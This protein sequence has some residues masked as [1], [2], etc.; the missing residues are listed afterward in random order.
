MTTHES[1]RHLDVSGVIGEDDSE[2]LRDA[3]HEVTLAGTR[4]ATVDLSGVTRLSGPAVRV[5]FDYRRRAAGSGAELTVVAEAGSAA[6]QVL[7]QVDLPH[8]FGAA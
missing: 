1:P 3:L 7:A 5:L 4:D 6:Q 8:A 2:E